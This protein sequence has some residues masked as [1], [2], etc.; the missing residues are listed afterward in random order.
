[1][2]VSFEYLSLQSFGTLHRRK[3]QGISDLAT[4]PFVRICLSHEITYCDT[5]GLKIEERWKAQRE[6]RKEVRFLSPFKQHL[7]LLPLPLPDTHAV[8]PSDFLVTII[9]GIPKH[10]SSA[11]S[12]DIC[13]NWSLLSLFQLFFMSSFRCWPWPYLSKSGP[14]RPYRS[15]VVWVGASG[16]PRV[17][18]EIV[19]QDS[20]SKCLDFKSSMMALNKQIA[21]AV[22]LG[23]SAGVFKI[24]DQRA[25]ESSK[26]GEIEDRL[27]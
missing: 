17:P 3:V 24:T 13:F 27:S 11:K 22:L 14:N 15:S 9:Q 5:K 12:F 16:P 4:P 10:P 23:K 26:R 19:R 6:G 1:M 20:M 21:D 18:S 2:W 25:K 8:A 7:L